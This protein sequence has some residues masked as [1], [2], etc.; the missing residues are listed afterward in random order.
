MLY[1]LK[2]NRGQDLHT[3][4]ASNFETDGKLFFSEGLA[5]IKARPTE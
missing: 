2:N 3:I 5:I 4:K 1:F